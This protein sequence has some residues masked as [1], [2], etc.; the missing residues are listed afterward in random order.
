[1]Y[2]QQFHDSMMA[3]V[4][5]DGDTS[6]AFPVTSG[7]KQGCVIAPTLFSMVFAAMLID[8]FQNCKDVLS[9]IRRIL[10][11]SRRM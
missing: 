1:V 5:G 3:L 11:C 10:P 4:L 9:H 8:A 6:E 2:H 7:V